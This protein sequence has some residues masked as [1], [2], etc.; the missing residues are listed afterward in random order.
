MHPFLADEQ[1]LNV[2]IAGCLPLHHRFV[3]LYCRDAKSAA[4]TAVYA[5]WLAAQRSVVTKICFTSP[6]QRHVEQ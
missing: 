2:E 4:Y 1:R 6:H 3:G 5:I